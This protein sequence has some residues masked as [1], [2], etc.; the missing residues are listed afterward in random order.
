MFT[1]R[2]FRQ[3][4]LWLASGLLLAACASPVGIHPAPHAQDPVCADVIL[5]LPAQ[6]AGMNARST[7]AQAAKAYVGTGGT[8]TI[9]CGVQPPGP[10]TDR[11]TTISTADYRVD[12]LSVPGEDGSWLFTT[13]GR[14]P[15]VQVQ[16]PGSVSF[17]DVELDVLSR[18]VARTQ[19]ERT[20]K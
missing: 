14:S 10:T 19:V 8:I 4:A 16:V 7:T 15:A 12:W 1:A 18:A 9:R 5:D 17:T 6:L 3:V 20:C 13:Y 2:R 11:C